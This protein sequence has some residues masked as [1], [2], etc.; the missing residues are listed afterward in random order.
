MLQPAL[1]QLCRLWLGWLR[2]CL[3]GHH[4]ESASRRRDTP[5]RVAGQGVPSRREAAPW[6]MVGETALRVLGCW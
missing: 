3:W 5:S 2:T 4:L 6:E 1:T